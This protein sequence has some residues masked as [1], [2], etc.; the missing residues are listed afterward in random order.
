MGANCDGRAKKVMG[1]LGKGA[2]AAS[3]VSST[4]ASRAKQ[5]GHGKGTSGDS[6]SVLSR[7]G[8]KATK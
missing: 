2:T 4:V 1:G 8:K 5:A 3:K 7:G 6:K